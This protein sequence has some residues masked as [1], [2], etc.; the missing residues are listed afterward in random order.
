MHM[1]CVSRGRRSLMRTRYIVLQPPSKQ[2]QHTSAPLTH[3]SPF[4]LQVSDTLM[5]EC[6]LR[7]AMHYARTSHLDTTC[8]RGD[9]P[10]LYMNGWDVFDALP[11]LWDSNIDQIPGTI[12]PLTVSE[13]RKLNQA[14]LPQ[15]SEEELD[16]QMVRK[17][18]GLCK[19]F[20][21]AVGAVTRIHQDNSNA[22]AWLC[23][24]R[25][26]KL[27]VLCKPSDSSKVAPVA[28]SGSKAHGTKYSGRLD[29]LDPLAQLSAQ[30]NGLQLF[31]T[32]L[33]PG[34]TILAPDGWWHYAVSLTPTITLMCN[35]WDRTNLFGLHDMF[36]E[37][38]ARGIDTARREQGVGPKV[39]V[40]DMNATRVTHNPPIEYQTMHSPFVYVRDLPRTDANVLGVL[41]P[42]S[43][44][45]CIVTIDLE[46]DGWL[47]TAE[48]FDKG[49]HGWLLAHGGKLGLGV[50]M[51][52]VSVV[53]AAQQ[54][55][56]MMPPA[57]LLKLQKQIAAAGLQVP[58]AEQPEMY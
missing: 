31:A 51:Q 39:L 56:N 18:R 28:T 10:V 19:L 40:A 26:R 43:K 50:L 6:T 58:K 13:N 5:A 1:S 9:A 4:S 20:I 30:R 23:N 12:Q 2:A 8:E 37:H 14:N 25:G 7:E 16:D 53:N 29:P 21:G 44:D 35:F 57:E 45:R 41:R 17:A 49:Q 34:Q 55:L 38:L 32:V 33:E 46:V 42:S 3:L 48:P 54:Q 36:Y 15:A 22:H 27:Y 47:R 11:Q 52:K 24:I